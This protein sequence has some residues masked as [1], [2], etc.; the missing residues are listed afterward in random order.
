MDKS[1]EK[2][3]LKA[4][5]KAAIA[6]AKWLG[7]RDKNAADDAAVGAMRKHFNKVNINGTVVIGEGE[8]D[9]APMLFI[10]EKVGTGK[11]PAVDIAVDP[12]ECTNNVAK[13]WPNSIAVLAAAPAGSLLH[14]PDTYM[15]KIAVGPKAKGKID[16]DKS[17][18]ENLH[19]VAEALGKPIN[20]LIVIVLERDRHKD[21]IEEIRRIGSRVKLITDGDISAALYPSMKNAKADILLGIGAAPE[22][23][24][25]CSAIKA[26]GGEIQG[27]LEFR[28]KEEKERARKMG[29]NDPGKKLLMNDLV[30]GN[31][32]V[33]VATGVSGGPLL[34][35]VEFLGEKA[36][37]NSMIINQNGMRKIEDTIN[38]EEDL[39][40]ANTRK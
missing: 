23:V 2:E 12:L 13:Y 16:L 10:G 8:R 22:G 17:T 26:L 34:E 6:S 19:S 4:T 37:V 3:L 35:G 9:K 28:N 30:K 15:N 18:E 36:N 40:E 5:Q 11:G 20:E 24:I 29:M 38:L 32:S 31:E 27:R 25:A 21:L 39:D 1:I 14:A 33:F 7:Y